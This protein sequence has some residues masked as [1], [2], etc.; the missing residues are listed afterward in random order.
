MSI[1]I[2]DMYLEYPLYNFQTQSLRNKILSFFKKKERKNEIIKGLEKINL[3][4]NKGDRVGLI[5]NNGSGKTS[6]IKVISNVISPSRGFVEID[7]DG[8]SFIEPNVAIEEDATGEENVHII[9]NTLMLKNNNITYNLGWIKEFSEL[10]NFFYLPYRTYS[11]GMRL[12]LAT[13]VLLSLKPKI[14]ILDEFIG[15]GDEDFIKK[16][17]KEIE[18]FKDKID[19]FICASH[20]QKFLNILCNRFVTLEN[21]K[22]ISDIKVK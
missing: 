7:D 17:S 18:T 2:K 15:G 12:R 21:G 1:K 4:I 22:I 9:L 6:L 16:I 3:E 10:K 20:N 19:I 5:G 13:S 11:N 14:L 8:L